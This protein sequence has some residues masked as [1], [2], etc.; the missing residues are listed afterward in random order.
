MNDR[1]FDVG[2]A[3]RELGARTVEQSDFVTNS[4]A[5]HAYEMLRL[6]PAQDGTCTR[7]NRGD[8]ETFG[9]QFTA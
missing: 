7:D 8:V 2:D 5:H 1:S 4:R 6:G 3:G 9:H